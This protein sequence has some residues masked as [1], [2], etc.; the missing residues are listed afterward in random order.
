MKAHARVQIDA[1]G[2]GFVERT[3]ENSGRMDNL[4]VS[5]GIAVGLVGGIVLFHAGWIGDLVTRDELRKPVPGW[6]R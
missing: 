5:E 3:A 4:E 1:G 2:L 6:L